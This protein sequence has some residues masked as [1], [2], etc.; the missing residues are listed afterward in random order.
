LI[1]TPVADTLAPDAPDAPDH[2]ERSSTNNNN[3]G[4]E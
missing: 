2:T 3:A 4:H 1:N